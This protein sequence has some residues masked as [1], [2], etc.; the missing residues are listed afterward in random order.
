MKILLVASSTEEIQA[1]LDFLDQNWEKISFSEYANKE[2]RI[3]PL[4]TG[5][6]SIFMPYALAKFSD[7]KN[8]DFVVLA[9]LAAS[10][11]RIVELGETVNVG[12][13]IF[14]DIGIEESN[15][16]FED[17]FD[18]KLHDKTRFPFFKG[19]IFNEEIINPL[20]QKVVKAIS[21]NRIPGTF[22]AIEALNK[23]YHAEIVSTNG[24]CFCLC[25]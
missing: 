10:T 3:F 21:V 16:E 2:T 7:I 18:L 5:Y 17:M 15:G 6:A 24:S 23:K 19:E 20:K 12:R 1:T 25:M 11:T 8:I 14:G 13:D 22:E 4:V 9:G